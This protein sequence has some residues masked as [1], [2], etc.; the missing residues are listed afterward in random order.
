MTYYKIIF[1]NDLYGEDDNYVCDELFTE[2]EMKK[3]KIPFTRAEKIELNPEDTKI[4]F[5]SRYEK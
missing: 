5:G 3:R 1:A 2:E 4:I